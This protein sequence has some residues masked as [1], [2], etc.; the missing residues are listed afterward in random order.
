MQIQINPK[1]IAAGTISAR[2]ALRESQV[3]GDAPACRHVFLRRFDAAADATAQAVDRARDAG[4]PLPVLA[5]VPISIKDLFDVAGQPTTAGSRSLA[6]AP[7]AVRDSTAVARLRAAGAVL[8]GHTNL[9][10]FAFS[11]VGINPHH[12]TP[13]NPCSVA[14]AL[15]PGG[16]SSGAAVSVATGASW[17]ALGSDT[18][19]SIRI[20]AALQGLV[21]FKN[22]Q[23]LTPL[24]G[25]IPL[26]PTLDT[27]CAITRSV[28]DAVL[29]HGILSA[30]LPQPLRRP[31]R[32]LRLGVPS[33]LMLD[34]LAPDVA[35]AFDSALRRLAAAGAQIETL[36]LPALTDMAGLQAQG[37]FA[38]A[39]AW[40]WHRQRLA[41]REA[42][43][44]PRVA[45][46]IK[47]GAAISAADYLDLQ[48]ARRSWIERVELAVQGFDAL[49][50]PTVPITAPPLAPLLHDDDA[51]FATNALL[52]R[53]PSV[54]NLLD[55]C[56][57]SLPCQAPGTLPVGLMVW[58]PA[59]CDD[60]VLG[61]GLAIEA[62]LAG[63]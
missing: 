62:V 11:G 14:E 33:T 43:Y 2:E 28:G 1:S 54:I 56:A 19:G 8:V 58:A 55:G 20:P 16:S 4:L 57:L 52:L 63:A 25:C 13:R 17:A 35:A 47:R 5:G 3:Q 46:R 60:A 26:S 42:D 21:G 7:P 12:G 37:G 30:R 38:A 18:G 34:A 23:R 9:T 10:E 6:D 36:P 49:L 48:Q 51:F 44:D 32:A 40:A 50:S 31:L 27:T 24:E 45:M 22:T 61:V 53:N 59:L 15:I 39:E 41:T 29:V